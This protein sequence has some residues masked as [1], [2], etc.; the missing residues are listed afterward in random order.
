MSTEKVSMEQAMHRLSEASINQNTRMEDL[1][2]KVTELYNL[3]TKTNQSTTEH[4]STELTTLET[5]MVERIGTM[6]TQTQEWQTNT[7]AKLN[8]GQQQWSYLTDTVRDMRAEIQKITAA[9]ITN[10]S[11]NQTNQ[12]HEEFASTPYSHRKSSIS[13]GATKTSIP[14]SQNIIDEHHHHQ[15][16]PGHTS[17]T[18]TQA[19]TIHTVVIPPTSAIPTFHGKTSENP[20]QFLIRIKEY[21]QTINQWNESS[22]L[23]GVSQFLRDSALDWY[24]QLRTT[25]RQPQTWNEFTILFLAQFNSPI[26]RARQEQEWRECKQRENETINEFVV[27]LRT[28][29]TEQ[30]PNETEADLIKHLMCKMRNDLLTMIGAPAGESLDEIILEIQGIE[31][32]IYRRSKYNRQPNYSQQ[33]STYANTFTPTQYDEYDQYEPPTMSSHE[34]NRALKTYAQTR[35][36]TQN[37]TYSINPARYTSYST[38]PNNNR[39]QEPYEIKCFTCGTKGHY[40]KNCPYQYSTE[41]Q[42][43]RFYPKN[44]HGAHG[45]RDPSAPQ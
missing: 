18:S 43:T 30:K 6:Q 15:H 42:Q 19:P 4:M 40:A 25:H 23:T 44:D 22:L 39:N 21:T 45:T 14:I 16:A 1:E 7:I 9:I 24:C 31:E 8:E 3:T 12:A 29:W 26:R 37:N 34:E 35:H 5:N 11:T 32:I 38:Q 41:Q 13:N 20:R 17:T 36:R 28:L 2:K 27:R 10:I 33:T